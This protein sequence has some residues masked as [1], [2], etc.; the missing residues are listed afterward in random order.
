[1]KLH[2]RS[3]VSHSASIVSSG[4][5]QTKSN[6]LKA[7]HGPSR[8]A[9]AHGGRS[10]HG[11]TTPARLRADPPPDAVPHG[12]QPPQ[13]AGG[14]SDWQGSGLPHISCFL[15]LENA[16]FFIKPDSETPHL[17]M[18]L[19]PVRP[20]DCSVVLCKAALP[21]TCAEGTGHPR[22]LP[23]PGHCVTST[24]GSPSQPQLPKGLGPAPC[25][26][27]YTRAF[28]RWSMSVS[29]TPP[30]PRSGRAGLR[31]GLGTS[32]QLTSPLRAGA[33]PGPGA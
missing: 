29:P 15:S 21:V 33:D 1:M 25:T 14:R 17:M 20:S 13:T 8:P 4:D 28:V 22:C 32:G 5:Y 24:M 16:V 26:P 11:A 7:P 18:A 2:T 19:P 6:P 10:V 12:A 9:S 31:P 30:H 23:Q 3:P 27:I